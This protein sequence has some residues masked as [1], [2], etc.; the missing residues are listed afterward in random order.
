MTTKT[1]DT[2]QRYSRGL[3]DPFA[4]REWGDRKVMDAFLEP[5]P[6]SEPE[7]ASDCS[8][9]LAEEQREADAG[10]EAIAYLLVYFLV[11]II[12]CVAAGAAV[13]WLS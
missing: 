10:V 1:N 13:A 3:T 9:L 7:A 4:Q 6:P 8:D 5:F 11:I 12:V 2:T